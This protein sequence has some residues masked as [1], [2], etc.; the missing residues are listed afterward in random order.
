MESFDSLIELDFTL[1]FLNSAIIC[2]EFFNIRFPCV[3][4]VLRD[5]RFK[6][7]YYQI[8]DIRIPKINSSFQ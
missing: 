8:L 3:D 1:L 2:L 6:S 5:L 4:N 7:A